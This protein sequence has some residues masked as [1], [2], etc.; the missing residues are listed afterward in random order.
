MVVPNELRW[1]L[2]AD[3]SSAHA[4]LCHR[5]TD[6][7]QPVAREEHRVLAVM[8]VVSGSGVAM[9]SYVVLVGGDDVHARLL[10]PALFAFLAP[11][12]VVAATAR[13]LEG[14]VVTVAWSLFCAFALRAD[15]QSSSFTLGHF[16]RNLTTE[17]RGFAQRGLNQPWIDGPGLYLGSTFT[18]EGSAT[19]IALADSE[20]FVVA[21]RA[22]GAMG[23]ALGPDALIVDLHGLADPLT[24][25][26]TAR[27]SRAS[28]P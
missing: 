7:A 11:L 15:G 17:D 24:A 1:T 18:A 26:S 21:T 10:M 20:D 3:R 4:R 6:G 22:I 5:R 23:Y 13:Y 25:L 28:R 12:F 16:G 27:V 8:A 2:P 14:I 19:G 9:G